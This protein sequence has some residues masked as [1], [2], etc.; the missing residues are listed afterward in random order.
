MDEK[1]QVYFDDDV[2]PEDAERLKLA[3]REAFNKSMREAF[4]Q[5]ATR[6]AQEALAARDNG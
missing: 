6:M 1:G 5:R 3:E 4:E 2:S